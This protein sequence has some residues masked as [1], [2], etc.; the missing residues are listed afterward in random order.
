MSFGNLVPL[1][2]LLLDLATR[3]KRICQ[4]KQNKKFTSRI[5]AI[6]QGEKKILNS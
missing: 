4:P 6:A 1:G 5:V 2:L 3:E